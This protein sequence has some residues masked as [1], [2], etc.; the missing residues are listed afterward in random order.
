[1]FSYPATYA[2][3]K[4]IVPAIDL[5]SDA[6]TSRTD[7]STATEK[8]SWTKEITEGATSG[9]D[10][11]YS[12]EQEFSVAGAC[13]GRLVTGRV[14]AELGLSGSSG[15]GD[16]NKSSTSVGRSQGIGVEK[17]GSFAVPTNY[18][19]LFTPYIFGQKKPGSVFDDEPIDSDVQTFGLLRTA[20]VA[21]PA[22]NDAGTWWRQSYRDAPDVALNHPSRWNWRQVAVENPLPSNCLNVGFGGTNMDCLDFSEARPDSLRDSNF[23]VMRGFFISSAQNP[24]EGPQ[25]TTAV[26]GDKLTL[27][28]RVYNYSFA[29]MSSGSSVHVRFYVQRLDKD[30]HTFVGDS[31][32]VNDADVVLSPI[33]PF[34]D[35]DGAPLNWVLAST[36]FDTTSFENDYLVF[37]VVVW[38]EDANGKLVAETE[39]HGL[40]SIPGELNSPAQVP[41]QKYSN[42]VGFYNSEFFVFPKQSVLNASPRNGEPASVDIGKVQLSASRAL[43]GQTID[44]SAELSATNNSAS[45]VTAVFYDGD[46]D[47]GGTIFGLERS[48]YIGENDT[49]QVMAP[50]YARSCGTHEL[51]VV[52]NKDTP[53]EIVRRSSPVI[54]DCG[55]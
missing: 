50:Y 39:R 17:P 44:V 37:W 30:K 29:P 20:F 54:V 47:A 13:C 16:L 5:L 14:S 38:I 43:A 15:F 1:M 46:P 49:Y 11:N 2:Q 48:P 3:L 12:F 42:N 9:F 31:I 45:G 18:N 27:Q 4:Q 35:D 28:A 41:I 34:S 26:A 23:H 52:V 8:A 32:L 36:T 33:P 19:Y 24:G 7:S 21:D 10:Q 51:F 25:L 6:Q 22:R 53:S 55:H 40:K